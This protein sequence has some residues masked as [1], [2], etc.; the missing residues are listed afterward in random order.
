[1]SLFQ[2]GLDVGNPRCLIFI[3]QI[4]IHFLFHLLKGRRVRLIAGGGEGEL[5]LG[6]PDCRLLP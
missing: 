4:Y 1:M 5:F 3:A 6:V 2:E